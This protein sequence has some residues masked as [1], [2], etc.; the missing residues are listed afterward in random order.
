[1]LDNL[2]NKAKQTVANLEQWLTANKLSL[3]IDKTKY[4]IFR[5][6]NKQMGRIADN[7]QIGN[8]VS[9]RGKSYQYIGMM[10]NKKWTGMSISIMWTLNE[11]NISQ[12]PTIWKHMYQGR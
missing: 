6:K 4:A 12:Y 2:M 9:K 5:N 3:N 7:L 8:D 11:W 1:M 10:W